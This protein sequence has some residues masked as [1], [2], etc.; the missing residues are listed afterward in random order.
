M[1]VLA[2]RDAEVLF[3]LLDMMSVRRRWVIADSAGHRLNRSKVS[4]LCPGEFV[5]HLVALS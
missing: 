5:I 2:E 3:M 1:T 4:P